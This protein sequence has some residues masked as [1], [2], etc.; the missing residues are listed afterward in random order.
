MTTSPPTTTTR[1]MMGVS[2]VLIT[3][4]HHAKSPWYAWDYDT[5]RWKKL[6]AK[7]SRQ[8]DGESATGPRWR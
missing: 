5:Q 1:A 6:N 2:S 8:L 4:G 7:Q 3:K